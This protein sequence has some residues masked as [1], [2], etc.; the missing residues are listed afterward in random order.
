MNAPQR[1]TEYFDSVIQ[2][3]TARIEPDDLA[4]CNATV[5]KA[6]ADAESASLAA[7]VD[8]G[9]ADADEPVID[10]EAIAW[11]YKKLLAYGVGN[12]GMDNAMMLDRLNLMLLTAQEAA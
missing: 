10:Y 2:R 8:S 9:L 6:R 11:A 5:A 7:Y 4:R 1:I 12:T 3:D